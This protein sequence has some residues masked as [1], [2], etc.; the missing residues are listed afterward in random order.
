L[1]KNDPIVDAPSIGPRTAKHFE[2][3]GIYTVAELLEATPEQAA[4]E[5]GNRRIK[6]ETIR[7]WQAQS[8]LACRVPE[9]RG[10]DAQILVGCGVTCPE[11]LLD[12][13]PDDLWKRVRAFVDTSEGKRIIRGGRGPDL[14]EVQNWILWARQSRTLRAA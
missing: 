1:H 11:D 6:T 13:E 10:H 3:I 8:E 7:D 5:L 2:R 12:M 14:E 9:L 4:Q